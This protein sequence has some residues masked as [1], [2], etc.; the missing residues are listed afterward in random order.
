MHFLNVDDLTPTELD[1]VLTSARDLKGDYAGTP[2]AEKSLAMLF[3]KASTRTRVSFE[4]GMTKLGGHAVFLGKDDIQLGRGEPVQDTARALACYADAVM[5]RV[6]DHETLETLA[7]YSSI[8]VVNGLSD[9]A[10]PVQTLADLL[11]IEEVVGGDA[12]VAWV[13]DGNNVAASFVVGAAMRGHDVS[14]ATPDAYALDDDVFDRAS[15]YSGTVTATT[16][17]EEAVAGADVVYTDVWVSMGDED[18]REQ[19]LDALQP[20][21]VNEDLLAGTDA[22]VMHCLPAHRGEE[23]TAD[24]LESE[25]SLVWRQAENRMHGQNG[26]LVELV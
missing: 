19:R 2:L 7:A 18:E 25:R 17:P 13:G 12:S 5:A 3:E 10:H 8:P 15:D 24:V 4:V 14:V 21:Q 9:E 20:Y 1:S 16:D 6:D 11:T 23:I 26:L 22:K